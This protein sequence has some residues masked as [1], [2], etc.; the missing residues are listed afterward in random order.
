MPR[1]Y[2]GTGGAVAPQDP[3]ADGRKPGSEGPAAI[4]APCPSTRSGPARATP[5][6]NPHSLTVAVVG[7]TGVVGRTMIQV[8]NEREFPV[9]DLRLLASGVGRTHGVR[10]RPDP[11]DRRGRPRG[12][13]WR[14]HRPLLGRRRRLEGAGTGRGRPRRDRHRQLVGLADGPDVP[15][16]VSQ[17]NPDD[18]EGHAGIIANPNCSTM[19]LAPVLMALRDAVGLERVVVDTYQSV[20]GTGA[21]ALAELEGQIRAH[22][23]GERQG[24]HGVPAPDRLQRAARDRRLPRQRLHQGGV[25]GRQREPQDPRPARPADL[26]HGR[27]R[28]GLRQPLRGGPRRDARPDHARSRARAVRGRAGRGRRGRPGRASLSAGDRGGRSRRGL[29]RPGP[30]RHV[31]RR[32]SRASPSGSC[33]TTCARARPRTRSSSP[34]C[35]ASAA[36]SPASAVERGLSRLEPPTAGAAEATA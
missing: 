6:M 9:G 25:E 5:Y 22:V 20:S 29:R 19:Q 1:S 27:P 32:R 18:L 23:T 30:P 4:L 12:L 15:L 11:R 7:A 36:G 34:R 35:S 26:V 21:D 24:R 28:P 14:R 33:R 8:L 10:R 16:V 3:L 31:D 17:V 2:A 13:R